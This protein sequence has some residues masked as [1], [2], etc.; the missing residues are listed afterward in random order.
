MQTEFKT[1]SVVGGWRTVLGRLRIGPA[2]GN[3]PDCWNWQYAHRARLDAVEALRDL[4]RYRTHGGYT[5]A[6]VMSDSELLCVPCVRKEYRQIL[7]ATIEA[8]RDG[9][10]VQGIANS[11][12]AEDTEYC[13]HCNRAVWTKE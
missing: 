10:A 7:T 1:R 12:D 13:A 6:A 5:W 4:A 8:S 9:W 11:G 3:A 2:F